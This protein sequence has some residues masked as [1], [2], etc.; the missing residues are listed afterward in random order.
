M[1][2]LFI[3]PVRLCLCRRKDKDENALPS[4]GGA[5]FTSKP[6]G[7]GIRFSRQYEE[8]GHRACVCVCVCG[9]EGG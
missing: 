3:S 5:L 7:C 2:F 1:S 4:A 6:V 8:T 9:G